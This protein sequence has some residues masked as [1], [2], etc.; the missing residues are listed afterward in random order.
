MASTPTHPTHSSTPS[1]VVPG[2]HQRLKNQ[3]GYTTPVFKEK[4]EQQAQVQAEVAS[5][6]R[7]IS[8]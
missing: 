6:V 5:K 3:P 4:D 7:L 1:L 2:H 8:I